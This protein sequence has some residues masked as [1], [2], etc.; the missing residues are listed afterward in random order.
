MANRR[1]ALPKG[2]QLGTGGAMYLKVGDR[3][4][5][6]SGWTGVVTEVNDKHAKVEFDNGEPPGWF[7]R[8]ED[9]VLELI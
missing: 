5:N 2:G 3:V 6:R 9:V 8:G 1:V 7:G 4:C